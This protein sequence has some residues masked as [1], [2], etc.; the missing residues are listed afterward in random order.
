MRNFVCLMLAA[1]M[2]GGC[3]TH[4]GESPAPPPVSATSDEAAAKAAAMQQ[5]ERDAAAAAEM[6]K[7]REQAAQ[8]QQA[9]AARAASER[10]AS[11]RAA[12]ERAASERAAPMAAPP[13]PSATP[14]AAAPRSTAPRA[15]APRPVAPQ[16][17]YVN[18]DVF[19][20]T[21]RAPTAGFATLPPADR[22][23][24]VVDGKLTYGK[25][26]IS[27]P[28]GHVAGELESP[29]W[30]LLEFKEDPSQH[31]ILQ[32]V[33][34]MQQGPFFASLQER[35]GAS[36]DSSAFVF[37]HGFNVSYRDAARRTAQLAYDLRFDGAPVF[38]SWPSQAALSGYFTD[39][40]S[41][42]RS[43][44][45][46]ERFLAQMA[47]NSAAR[48]LYVIGH[49]MGTRGVTQALVNLLKKRP[50][51]R[52][53]FRGIILAAPDIDA[54]VFRDQLAPAMAQA[55]GRV[56]LYSSSEDL[57]LQA[58]RQVNRGP[59]AGD[60]SDG[61][62]VMKGVDTIDVTGVDQSVLAHSYF[63]ESDK[64]MEDIREMIRDNL[65]ASGR[66]PLQTVKEN[67]GIFWRLVPP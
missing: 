41:I 65:P 17:D 38:Y 45:L 57:A 5:A 7:A 13:P 20:A 21:N 31:V 1:L 54:K 44:P 11:E 14:R 23:T 32:D 18:V 6:A 52:G 43:V 26:R 3:A 37:V 61:V 50:E 49:S 64:V 9:N 56:T 36:R 30:Y 10:A 63:M 15:A 29:R 48:N 51:L 2:L 47:D 55:S 19:Y 4:V 24:A 27:I 33:T 39:E 22:F 34:R 35:V 40:Q 53:R 8:K 42:A 25:A 62:L 58:S 60:S 12:A 28:K 67:N 59:R 46:I 66:K 16:S